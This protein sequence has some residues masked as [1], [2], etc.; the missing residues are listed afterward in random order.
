MAICPND[1]IT[2]SATRA[3]GNGGRCV[4]CC[5]DEDGGGRRGE[6][7]TEG[8]EFAECGGK[9]ARSAPGR[10]PKRYDTGIPPFFLKGE[11][12]GVESGGCSFPFVGS[13]KASENEVVAEGRSARLQGAC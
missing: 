6:F 11:K 1:L 10:V 8:T 5:F 13:E 12:R 3:E 4:S 9:R 7:T 2:I